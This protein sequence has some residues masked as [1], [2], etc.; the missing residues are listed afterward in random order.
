M[1][2]YERRNSFVDCG[3]LTR[4][5]TWSRSEVE[6]MKDRDYDFAYFFMI[7]QCFLFSSQLPNL[8]VD[9]HGLNPYMLRS[10]KSW[11]HESFSTSSQRSLPVSIS[12]MNGS[13]QISNCCHS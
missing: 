3:R 4:E 10:E 8:H 12:N 6:P 5:K 1:M 2:A 13:R 9:T 11:I 7:T